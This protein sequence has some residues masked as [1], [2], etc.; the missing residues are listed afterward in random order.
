MQNHRYIRVESRNGAHIVG[1]SDPFLYG[2]IVAE[3]L[4]IELSQVVRDVQPNLLVIEFSGV[5]AISSAVIGS[6]MNTRVKILQSGGKIRFC[7]LTS[8]VAGVL[9]AL[10]LYGTVF[11]VHA[12]IEDAINAESNTLGPNIA[13]DLEHE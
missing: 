11:E 2:E 7:E 1:F 4:K 8:S 5:K 6:L 13:M 9:R 12:T 10:N 3:I